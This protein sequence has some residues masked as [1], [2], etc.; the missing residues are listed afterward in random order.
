MVSPI[1]DMEGFEIFVPTHSDTFS[2]IYISI[3]KTGVRLSRAALSHINYPKYVNVFFDYNKKR[4]MVME[5]KKGNQN[6]MMLSKQANYNNTLN[7]RT[8][9]KRLLDMSGVT[10]GTRINGRKANTQTPAVIFEFGDKQ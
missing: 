6:I 1:N 5:G 3:T 7:L 9:S 10:Y 4:L 2:E 8:F